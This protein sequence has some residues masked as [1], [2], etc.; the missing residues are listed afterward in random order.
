MPDAAGQSAILELIEENDLLSIGLVRKQSN[1]NAVLLDV[2]M[3]CHLDRV[4]ELAFMTYFGPHLRFQCIL[5]IAG[6]FGVFFTLQS[7]FLGLTV[8]CNMYLPEEL[9]RNVAR[10]VQIQKKIQSQ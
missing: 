10:N 6:F 3:C 8:V 5:I 2:Q 4:K 1:S 7:Y 9:H